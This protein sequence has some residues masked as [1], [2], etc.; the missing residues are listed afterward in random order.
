MVTAVARERE[1]LEETLL[2]RSRRSSMGLRTTVGSVS[3]RPAR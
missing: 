3:V 2:E 1:S